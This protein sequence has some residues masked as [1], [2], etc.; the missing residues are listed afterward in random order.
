MRCRAIGPMLALAI[1]VASLATEAQQP[2]KAQRIAVLD[3][4]FPPSA[5]THTSLLDVDAFRQ[6]LRELGWVEGQNIAIEWRWAEGSLE[7]FATLVA[8]LVRLPVKVLVV[9]N[10]T[11]AKLTK[12][13]TTT[14][15]IVVVAGGSLLEAGLVASL[16]RPGG[17]ITGV[18]VRAQ[19][20]AAKQ[21]ELLKQAVPR[22]TRVAVLGGQSW[23]SLPPEMEEVAR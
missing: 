17:N 9:P 1:L 23:P 22:V 12:Q 21:L 2:K 15:P 19:E 4:N 10:V 11:T 8:E 3:L 18:H 7:R 5:S 13:A 16:A 14:I 20:L 6:G